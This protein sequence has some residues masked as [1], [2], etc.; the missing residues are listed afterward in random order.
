VDFGTGP[1]I[2]GTGAFTLGVWIRTTS[3]GMIINQR[4]PANFNGEYV[5]QVQNGKINWAT[6]GNNQYGFNFTSNASVNDGNSHFITVTRL[7]NGTGQIYIDGRLDSSQVA[8]PVP[9]GSGFHVYIGEDV[10]NAVDVGPSY[11]NNFVGQIDEVQIYHQTLTAGQIQA[12]AVS[13]YNPSGFSSAGAWPTALNGLVSWLPGE[14]NFVDAAGSNPG[15]P[16]PTGVSFTQGQVGQAFQLNGSTGKISLSDSPSLDSASFSVGGWFQLTQA[17]AAGSVSYLASKYDGNARGWTLGVNSNLIPTFS[18][19]SQGASA[20]PN[21]VINGTANA[22][23]A[24]PLALNQWYYLSATFDTTTGT[25]TLY[26]NGTAA[27]TATLTPTDYSPSFTPLVIGSASWT[28][29]GYFAGK[30]DEFAFYNRAL[31]PAEVGLL[32]TPVTT[33]QR[34]GGRTFGT[35]VDIGATEYQYDLAVTGSAPATATPGAFLQYTFTVTNRGLDPVT[36]IT[37]ADTLPAGVTLNSAGAVPYSNWTLGSISSQFISFFSAAGLAPGASAT[38]YVNG[39]VNSNTAAGTV[40]TNTASVSPTTYDMNLG[41]NTA[42]VTTT[43]VSAI[44]QPGDAGFE[45]P[46]VGT[47]A[48]GDYLYDPSGTAWTFSG[49]S[50]V[51]GNGSGFTAGNPPAPQGT[52]VGFLQNAG[53]IS[54]AVTFAAGTYELTFSAAQRS[55]FGVSTQAVQVQVDGNVV[56]TFTPSGT[57]YATFTTSPFTVA[58]G[59][60]TI[61]FV[62]LNPRGGDNTALL[63]NVS[64]QAAPTGVDIH[65]QPHDAVVGQPVGPVVVAVV[66]DNGDTVAGSDIPV[67]LSISSGPKGAVLEGVTTVRAVNGVA[68]FT[69]LALNMAGTYILTATSGKLDAD[70]SNPIVISPADVSGD[71]KVYRGPLHKEQGKSG[72]FEQEVTI[73]NTGKATLSGQSALVLTDLPSGV[74]LQGASGTYQGSPYVDILDAK[75]ALAPGQKVTV[76][77]TFLVT[78]LKDPDDLSYSTETLLGI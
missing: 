9:L 69:D 49:T 4:D 19:Y 2:V 15:T 68:T 73:T 38:I 29:G 44:T 23:A 22:T 77:L 31:S 66:D 18:L 72:V 14:G 61:K 65:G 21:G 60:H 71:V 37:F 51:A 53:S 36:N 17:P 62:G 64:I 7:A 75:E 45:S 16:S 32:S 56:G 33:D 42:T 12:L 48:F 43:V 70:F 55:N 74:T 13:P 59:S 76:T 40:L 26:V 52:Q 8:A 57:G 30:V 50:G 11:S 24:T 28:N 39:T 58:A 78:G 63:D 41:N 6:F 47:G 67:T 3:D 5:L 27:A 20:G 25:A 46:V 35:H 1:D 10:R 54:Q 34:G